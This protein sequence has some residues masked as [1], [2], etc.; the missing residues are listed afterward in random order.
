MAAVDTE[1]LVRHILR[2]HKLIDGPIFSTRSTFYI[3]IFSN[4]W[5]CP[6]SLCGTFWAP[7]DLWF[8]L[9]GNNETMIKKTC[10]SQITY[11]Q[12][13]HTFQIPQRFSHETFFL[14]KAH[15]DVPTD[16]HMQ[17]TQRP[18]SA[19]RFT[20][21]WSSFSSL[22]PCRQLRWWMLFN[23]TAFFSFSLFL[24]IPNTR[25]NSIVIVGSSSCY[26]T[27]YTTNWQT[28]VHC[29]V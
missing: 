4:S 25:V 9:D 18:S 6:E 22:S 1:A 14:R 10:T 2:S 15:N 29:W 12:R 24:Q 23:L 21:G 27:Q 8:K 3:L 11:L 20:A 5:K 17:P 16:S 7:L 19:S 13:C 28:L 26:T